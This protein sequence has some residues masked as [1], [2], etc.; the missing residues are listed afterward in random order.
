M[1]FVFLAAAAATASLPKATAID[2]QSWFNA[3]DYPYE[4]QAKGIEGDVVFQVDVDPEGKPT[5]CRVTHSSGS[6]ALD[7]ATCDSVLAR[8]KFKPAM[9]HRKAVAGHYSN[10]ASWR[11]EGTAAAANG[12]LATI[13]DFTKDADHPTCSVV[14]KGLPAVSA[15]EQAL[16][17]FGAEGARAKLSKVVL[18]MSVSGRQEQPYAGDPAWGRRVQFVAIDLYPP[19]AGGKPYCAIVAQE[20]QA[21]GAAPCSR[22]ADASTLSDDERRNAKKI[23]LEETVFSAAQRVTSTDKCKSGESAAEVRGCA[24]P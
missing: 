16:Q 20:G 13:L 2:M 21:A 4:A 9:R 23:H 10:K 7:K 5:A 1:L 6:P 14:N 15:C 11:L 19:K 3:D 8:A 12:Y 18:L 17:K 24:S 22:Y